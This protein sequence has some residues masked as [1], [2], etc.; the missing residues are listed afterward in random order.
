MRI[1][2][3]TMVISCG[4]CGN[5]IRSEVP[6]NWHPSK[7]LRRAQRDLQ[8]H[9]KTHSFAE[10]LRFEIRQDLEQV[11]EEQRASIVRDVY[12]TLLGKTVDGKFS[13]GA[14]DSRGAYSVDEALG[15]VSMYQ[16]W[17]SA[18]SCGLPGCE[19]H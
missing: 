10:V 9:L 17:R 13:L 2:K 14:E 18:S 5:L 11:P 15:G 7:Q 12:R 8:A 19:Q 3:T 4:I 1:P 16:L 6:P